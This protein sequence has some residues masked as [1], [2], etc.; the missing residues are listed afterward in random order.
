[1]D[2]ST[3]YMKEHLVMAIETH[4]GWGAGDTWSNKDFEKLS[5]LI[6][7]TT[8][9]RLSVTTLKRIWGRAEWVANPSAV[10]L[11]ILSEFLGYEHWRAFVQAKKLQEPKEKT[12]GKSKLVKIGIPLAALI[13]ISALVWFYSQ[14][15]SDSLR[16][17]ASLKPENFVFKSRPVSKGIP[18]SVI[19]E[20]DASSADDNS[21]IEIQQSWDDSKRISLAKN[22]SIATS[23]YYHPGFFKSKLVVD[24]SIVKE[25]DVFITT[26]D[27]LGMIEQEPRPI[28]LNSSDILKEGKLT[29]S[30]E[31]VSAHNLDPRA[32]EIFVSFYQVK[33]FGELHTNSFEMSVTLKNDFEGGLSG[34]CQRALV[35]VLY[36][37][38]AIGIPLSKKGCVS[39]LTLMTFEKFFDGKKNDLSGFGVD[40]SDYVDLKC[41]SKNQ[42]LDVSID[43]RLV[44]STEVPKVPKKI[45]G[46]SIHLEGAGSVRNVILRKEHNPVYAFKD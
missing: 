12:L 8:S 9:K 35:Y 30:P 34:A 22:D 10:T 37:G 17:T 16:S 26:E 39:E 45:I 40:F 14:K 20:Y 28:Y 3:L 41:I 38:G 32:S 29:I 31:V 11:D 33:D 6:F 19:F 42:K 7:N 36:E 5:Q 27:W 23:I 24:D 13:L 44:F 1:M 18:N 43:G 15:N 21:K 25:N 2:K 4:L 46:I